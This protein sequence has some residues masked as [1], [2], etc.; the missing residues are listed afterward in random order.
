MYSVAQED[1][2]GR[3]CADSAH[4]TLGRERGRE[5]SKQ[6]GGCFQEKVNPSPNS[7]QNTLVQKGKQP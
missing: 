6:S 5:G 1:N 3:Q 7:S 2:G 4:P